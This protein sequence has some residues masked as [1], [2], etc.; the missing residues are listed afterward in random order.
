MSAKGAGVKTSVKTKE[1]SRCKT[2]QT[3]VQTKL[4]LPL[5][6]IL[7]SSPS[8]TEQQQQHQQRYRYNNTV[9]HTSQSRQYIMYHFT[10]ALLIITSPVIIAVRMR[11]TRAPLVHATVSVYIYIYISSLIYVYVYRV[12]IYIYIYTRLYTESKYCS[13]SLKVD[14]RP[15]GSAS[16]YKFLVSFCLAIRTRHNTCDAT[17]KLRSGYKRRNVRDYYCSERGRRLGATERKACSGWTEGATDVPRDLTLPSGAVAQ[18]YRVA[19]MRTRSFTLLGML[20]R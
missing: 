11:R 5:E 14:S 1:D 17:R 18:P 19:E 20:Y 10:T 13:G 3:A 4:L 2:H 15:L 6:Q 8:K 16:I 7:S 12:S 9:L